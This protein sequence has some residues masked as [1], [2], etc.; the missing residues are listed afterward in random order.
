LVYGG[1][2]VLHFTEKQPSP[3]ISCYYGQE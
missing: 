1:L 2:L 3:R